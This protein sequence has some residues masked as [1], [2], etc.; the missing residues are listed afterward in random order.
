MLGLHFRLSILL[1]FDSV[2][3]LDTCPKAASVGLD[4][5]SAVASLKDYCCDTKIRSTVEEMK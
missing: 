3:L 2:L 4:W 1:P 5:L